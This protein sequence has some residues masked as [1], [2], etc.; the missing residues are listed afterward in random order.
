MSEVGR[1]ITGLCGW[2]EYSYTEPGGP[3]KRFGRRETLQF[4]GLDGRNPSS[5]R[6]VQ[7]LTMN[8]EQSSTG[9]R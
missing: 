3:L 7:I 5:T 4:L 2:D 1:T 8:R 9:A 6:R